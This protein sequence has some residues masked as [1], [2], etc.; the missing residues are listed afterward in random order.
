MTRRQNLLNL[1]VLGVALASAGCASGWV[2]HA[3]FSADSRRL[4]YEDSRYPRVYILSLPGQETSTLDGRLLAVDTDMRRLIIGDYSPGDGTDSSGWMLWLEETLAAPL[5]SEIRAVH[6]TLVMLGDE[7][8]ECLALP[9]LPASGHRPAVRVRF[10][11][12]PDELF[13]CV[14][15]GGNEPRRYY[16]LKLGESAWVKRPEQFIRD[17]APPWQTDKPAGI[18][19]GGYVYSFPVYADGT[20]EPRAGIDT[21]EE[22]SDRGFR[23]QLPSPDGRWCVRIRDWEESGECASLFDT[24]TGEKHII[25]EKNDGLLDVAKA[26]WIFATMPVSILYLWL[27]Y[28][29]GIGG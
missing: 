2:R 26:T 7:K 19:T 13:A 22:R 17:E 4:V 14:N 12:E 15:P 6:L 24:Q 1:A 20:G 23:V 8:S 25:L 27:R 29:H 16:E 5:R 11:A 3:K 10:K 18:L 9:D 21:L 28:P